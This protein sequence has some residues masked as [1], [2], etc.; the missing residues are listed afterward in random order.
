MEN[1][2]KSLLS[3]FNCN[4]RHWI[5][6]KL[7]PN[8]DIP[9]SGENLSVY[10]IWIAEVMLQQTKL[11]VALPYWKRWM[12]S[13]PSLIALAN[14]TEQE[15]LLHWQGLG[16]YSRARRLYSSAKI[17]VKVIE[18]KY[19]LDTSCWSHNV[20][21]WMKLPGI[22]RSTA[23]SII[24]S[25]FNL[26]TALLDG[27]LKRIFSRLLA[28]KIPPINDESRLWKFSEYLLDKKSP[29]IF[30]QAL[31]DLGANICTPNNP[32]CVIC[33]INEHCIAYS[34]CDPNNFPV[35]VLKK[36]IPEL[37]IGIGVVINSSDEIL[38]AQR[39]QNQ[40]M[41]GMWEFPGGKQEKNELIERT[42]AREIKEE[43]GIDVHIG[44]KL[45]AFDH[46]YTHK[47]F[48]FI[49]HICKIISGEPR[50][51]Q[52]QQLKWVELVDLIQYPFPAA[53]SRI[54]A[55]L[56]EYVTHLDDH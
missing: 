13:F 52:S 17:L 34:F 53:N 18:P 37:V 45:I 26:P 7:K 49:V 28:S 3:W 10:G 38:I 43:I 15:V 5:P 12:K 56:N 47:K 35:K 1:L 50:P 42:I 27:N 9:H 36:P 14:A 29:R 30:N 21:N 31:M 2:Q 41:G 24:S 44:D 23:G 25:A 6:W 51:I 39:L 8:G 22:G 4:G 48:H 33:P 16:Y 32:N 11:K 40:S 20:D 46:A 19:S 54:I 55:K